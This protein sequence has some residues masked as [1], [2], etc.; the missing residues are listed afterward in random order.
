MQMDSVM[1][2]KFSINLCFKTTVNID[3]SKLS[4]SLVSKVYLVRFINLS[5]DYNQIF[6]EDFGSFAVIRPKVEP[7]VHLL[8][9]IIDDDAG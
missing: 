9:P 2:I 3:F 1:Q 8:G 7:L 4:N 6:R 5:N